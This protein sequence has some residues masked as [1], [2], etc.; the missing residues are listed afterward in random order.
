MFSGYYKEYESYQNAMDE[1]NWFH[2]GDVGQ[3]TEV[4]ENDLL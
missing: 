3:W 4:K 1:D 2:T